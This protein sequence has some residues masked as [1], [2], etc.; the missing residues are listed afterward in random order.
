MTTWSDALAAAHKILGKDGKL[1][2]AR[3][4][5]ASMYPIV[6]KAWAPFNKA[7]EGIE[8]ALLDL[9]N[10]FSQSKNTFKQYGDLVDGQD[11]GLK[12]D[13]PKD[14]KRIADV[15]GIILKA[16]GTLEDQC[17]QQ[18][19]TLSKLDSLVANLQKVKQLKP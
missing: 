3:V 14:K 16:L 19:D 13:D 18:I 1:P 11:F 2:K 17:D 4:D 10:A 9:E 6:E 5:P 15:T 7:R 12:E 8:K